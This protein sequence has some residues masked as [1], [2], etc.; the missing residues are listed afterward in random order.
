MFNN[1]LPPPDDLLVIGITGRIGAGKTTAG[2]YLSS[3]YGFQYLR[4]SQVL[5]DWLANDSQGKPH[6]QKIGWEVMEKGMQADLNRR[7]ISQINP[8]ADAAVDGLRHPLDYESLKNTFPSSFHLLFI[9]SSRIM[10]WDREKKQ[11]RSATID[12]FE[13][14]DAHPVEQQIEAFQGRA[15]QVIRNEGS[16]QG[17]YV[18]LDEAIRRLRVGRRI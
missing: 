12:A 13:A 8:N 11:S 14:A 10:R 3:K 9:E 4:Y 6:L 5:S 18:S 7:L 16:L 2:K 1:S 15:A 17:F